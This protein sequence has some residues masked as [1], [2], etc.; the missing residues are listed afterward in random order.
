MVA[1]VAGKSEYTEEEAAFALGVTIDE[2]RALVRR[3]FI[4]D[5]V[6]GDVPIPVFRPTDL[7]LI[8]MLSESHAG[9]RIR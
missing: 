7:L 1:W 5:D 2:L 8:R 3:H 4:N 6:G 9:G